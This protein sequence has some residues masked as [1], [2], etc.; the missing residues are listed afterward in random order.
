MLLLSI[1]GK[2]TV[3]I[4][5]VWCVT[6]VY[7]ITGT[8]SFQPQEVTTAHNAAYE[9]SNLMTNDNPAYGQSMRNRDLS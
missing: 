2:H 9:F 1:G 3:S 6:L 8:A 7:L 5:L 4:I